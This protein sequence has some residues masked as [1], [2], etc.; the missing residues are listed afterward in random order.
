MI[1]INKKTLIII[2]TI[3]ATALIIAYMLFTKNNDETITNL[4]EIE[5]NEN[6]TQNNQKETNENKIIIHITGAI[7]KEGIYEL[8][9]NSRIAD[10]IE[11][12]EGLTENANIQDINLA[13]VL[14]DGEKIHIPTKEE[15]KKYQYEVNEII[16]NSD[17]LTTPQIAEKMDNLRRDMFGNLMDYTEIK[18][19]YNQLMLECFPYM[20]NRVNI[21]ADHLKMAIQYAMVGNYIDF[22]ALENVNEIKLKTQLDEAV[23]IHIDPK[24]LAVFQKDIVNANRLVYF[25]DNCGEIVTDKLFIS[26]L[27]DIN[28]DLY[29]SVI[30]RGKPVLND[31]TLEDAKYIHMENVAQK[32]IGNGT[33]MPGNVIGAI[34]QEA[35]EEI[36]NVDLLISK[37]QGNYEG[38]SGCGLNIYY[39]FL[40]KCEMFMRR[41]GV[42]QFTGIMTREEAVK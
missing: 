26:T 17:G 30:V 22:G 23:N 25:T 2:I 7:K 13:Y 18:K 31:A 35:M 27:R 38:L 20:K 37:G 33:G 12:A 24:L 28:P 42:E 9:E 10:A 6:D 5:I 36:K 3:I 11:A 14:E 15:I 41:F 32:V 21:A 34:S 19:H 16:R 4:E 40:C 1:K 8:K 39:F 29:I